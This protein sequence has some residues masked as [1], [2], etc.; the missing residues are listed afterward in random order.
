MT[1]V[2]DS[3]ITMS[4]IIVDERTDANQAVLDRA[5]RQ[6][7]AAPTLWPIEVANSLAMAQRRGRMTAA[8]RNQA[9]RDLQMMQVEIDDQ[10]LSHVWQTTMGLADAHS[11]TV[12]DATYL[13][14]AMRRRLSLATLDKA[15]IAAAARVGVEIL[16]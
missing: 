14:L 11:L 1:I 10:T 12:Y 4:W 7:M 5:T 6:G 15:L 2:I 13:E 8:L 3:S 9:L 16:P